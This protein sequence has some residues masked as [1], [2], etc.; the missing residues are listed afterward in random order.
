[1]DVSS[2]G[3]NMFRQEG[4]TEDRFNTA[5]PNE[6]S[7]FS[8]FRAIISCPAKKSFYC[9]HQF[10]FLMWPQINTR[11]MLLQQANKTAWKILSARTEIQCSMILPGHSKPL[12]MFLPFTESPIWFFTSSSFISFCAKT[13]STRKVKAIVKMYLIVLMKIFHLNQ[14]GQGR[15]QVRKLC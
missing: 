3:L 7:F 13:E 5:T 2:S 11:A 15:F 12:Q 8:C 10:F 4:A 14:F 9:F 1:M 6:V